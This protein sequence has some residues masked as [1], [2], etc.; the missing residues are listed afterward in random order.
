MFLYS[1]SKFNYAVVVVSKVVSV[2]GDADD[3]VVSL[4]PT[5]LCSASILTI[6]AVTPG[7]K[8]VAYLLTRR[9][10]AHILYGVSKDCHTIVNSSSPFSS[11]SSLSSFS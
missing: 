10:S 8:N 9:S 11:T 2:V 1:F 5:N 3:V 4:I 7:P 6:S